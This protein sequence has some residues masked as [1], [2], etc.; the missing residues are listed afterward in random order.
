[1]TIYYNIEKN[2]LI[3]VEKNVIKRLVR[4]QEGNKK[5]K[6]IKEKL[7][8]EKLTKENKL[9]SILNLQRCI[10]DNRCV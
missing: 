6:L 7:I 3:I 9:L 8:K 1:M 5:E 4:F 10:V 2:K